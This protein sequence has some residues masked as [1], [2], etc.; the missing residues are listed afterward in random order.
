MDTDM[1]YAYRL[2]RTSLT[3]LYC[4]LGRKKILPRTQSVRSS[5][6][7]RATKTLCIIDTCSLVYMAHVELARKPLQK[8]LW[9]EFDVKYSEAVSDEFNMSHVDKRAGVNNTKCF[10]RS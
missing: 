2:A 5:R 9:E 6:R 3:L 10:G 8:W 1:R 4:R 7:T